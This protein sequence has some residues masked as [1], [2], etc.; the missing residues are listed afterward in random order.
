MVHR[1]KQEEENPSLITLP[2]DIPGKPRYSLSEDLVAFGRASYREMLEGLN[3]G[4]LSLP[5]KEYIKDINV[6]TKKKKVEEK[7]PL[8]PKKESTQ[9]KGLFNIFRKKDSSPV[10]DTKTKNSELKNNNEISTDISS[11]SSVASTSSNTTL[12]NSSDNI[13]KEEE[14]YKIKYSEDYLPDFPINP[15]VGLIPFI[16]LVG[17]KNIGKRIN[18]W[19]HERRLA[20]I[21]GQQ[22][23]AVAVGKHVPF[24]ESRDIRLGLFEERQ[25]AGRKFG[26]LP[27]MY[28]IHDAIMRSLR[29]I[30][31]FGI[32]DEQDTERKVDQPL[33]GKVLVGAFGPMGGEQNL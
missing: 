31:D 18:S 20:Q 3:Q 14:E 7:K 30:Q 32:P 12:V 2:A 11:S 6:I 27:K 21:Y 17:K 22:A 25:V 1:R 33:K 9:K 29:I 19:F 8:P 23:V 15:V 4:F 13:K 26:P 5:P 24:S 16:N 28:R 10:E